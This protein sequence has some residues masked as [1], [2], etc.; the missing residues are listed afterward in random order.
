MKLQAKQLV[1]RRQISKT[2]TF[3]RNWKG[4]STRKSTRRQ[5]AKTGYD[6]V[7]RKTVRRK[8][9]NSN[10]C[11]WSE[12]Q[13]LSVHQGS[14]VQIQPFVTRLNGLTACT[15]NYGQMCPRNLYLSRYLRT[16]YANN[17]T[18]NSMHRCTVK[19]PVY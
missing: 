1:F 8:T 6:V 2:V 13:E 17:T 9:L 18:T 5:D 4:L 3:Y 15:C 19:I 14:E 11:A 16:N 10:Y 7:P 12:R